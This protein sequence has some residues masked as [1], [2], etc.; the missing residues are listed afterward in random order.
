[1]LFHVICKLNFCSVFCLFSGALT[2]GAHLGGPVSHAGVQWQPSRW[3]PSESLWQN[4]GWC[5]WPSDKS[6]KSG[7]FQM[8]QKNSAH[9]LIT[10]FFILS[11]GLLH[12][13]FWHPT[14]CCYCPCSLAPHSANGRGAAS[15][16]DGAELLELG[17]V[18]GAT[19]SQHCL[20][21]IENC[22]LAKSSDSASSEVW[23]RVAT[24]A[25][26]LVWVLLL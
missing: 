23:W 20:L 2:L 22:R 25:K 9:R 15:N 3:A 21:L 7:F 12:M 14:R 18:C 1:M 19:N 4:D 26:S 11:V 17:D 13:N 6:V 24:A 10:C 16:E 5:K 8:F